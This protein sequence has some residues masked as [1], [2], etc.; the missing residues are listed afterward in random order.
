MSRQTEENAGRSTTKESQEAVSEAAVTA[1]TTK[2]IIPTSNVAELVGFTGNNEDAQKLLN[3][4]PRWT[5]E[6]CTAA[7]NSSLT[8][9][10]DYRSNMVTIAQAEARMKELLAK[11]RLP[12]TDTT[13]AFVLMETIDETS[14][15]SNR[16]QNEAEEKGVSV[17]NIK[18]KPGLDA[19]G[20]HKVA[21]MKRRNG[22]FIQQ[23][24]SQGTTTETQGPGRGRMMGGKIELIH[25]ALYYRDPTQGPTAQRNDPVSAIARYRMA[26]DGKVDCLERWLSNEK[27]K[28]EFEDCFV[29]RTGYLVPIPGK[30]DKALKFL[31]ENIGEFSVNVER[32]RTNYSPTNEEPDREIIQVLNFAPALGYMRSFFTEEELSNCH[33]EKQN[34]ICDI[35]LRAQY[36][37]L[38]QA[39]IEE[40]LLHP[41]KRVSLVLTAVGGGCFWN[42]PQ[43]IASAIAEAERTILESGLGNIDVYLS[44]YH[45]SPKKVSEWQNM[46]RAVYPA[47]KLAD[48]FVLTATDCRKKNPP[49][50]KTVLLTELYLEDD[51]LGKIAKEEEFELLKKPGIKGIMRVKTDGKEVGT[52]ALDNDGGAFIFMDDGAFYVKEAAGW[53]RYESDS[54]QKETYPIWQGRH[55]ILPKE[56]HP[57][58][59]M[60][61]VEQTK[62][63]I[64]SLTRHLVFMYNIMLRQA[65]DRL[66]EEPFFKA[67]QSLDKLTSKIDV[68]LSAENASDEEKRERLTT[69]KKECLDALKN[70]PLLGKCTSHLQVQTAL[71]LDALEKACDALIATVAPPTINPVTM[72]GATAAAASSGSAVPQEISMNRAS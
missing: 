35:L 13:G 59:S 3:P 20:V 41:G 17:E 49:K 39:A 37:L 61:V 29:Y 5:R 6:Q 38:A 56:P 66:L 18:R 34:E 42:D 63:Q 71:A 14:A 48:A 9:I 30:E 58:A 62:R 19:G 31:R 36:R 54:P 1:N 69:T 28:E 21:W 44:M 50:K 7:E 24:A 68:T 33:K 16:M 60:S 67:C 64:D 12:S 15:E 8:K 47:S 4:N 11:P 22:P 27:L 57:K 23:I 51:L 32:V 26:T 65:R 52:L 46:L 25:P 40:A 2:P 72:F 43:V 10:K 53:K 45:S 55:T 70:N